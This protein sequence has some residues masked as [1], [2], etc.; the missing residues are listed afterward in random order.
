VEAAPLIAFL[1][2]HALGGTPFTF[3]AAHLEDQGGRTYPFFLVGYG[4]P[5][6][7]SKRQYEAAGGRGP[8][9][10]LTAI[11]RDVRALLSAPPGWSLL[12]LDF[13]AC[14]AAI[15]MALSGDEQLARDLEDDV[16]QTIGDMVAPPNFSPPHRRALGKQLNNSMLFGMTSH[17]VRELARDTLGRDALDGTGEGVSGAWWA[18]YPRLAAFRDRV[19]ALV[20]QAQAEARGVEIVAPSGRRSRFSPA[21]VAGRVDKGQGAKSAEGAW[22][23]LFSA[24]FRAAEADLLERTFLHF[25]E[26]ATG[27]QIMLPIYDGAVLSAPVGSEDLVRTALLAAARTAAGEIGIQVRAEIKER[28]SR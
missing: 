20:A 18:R 24:A 5:I 8:R 3:N 13:K 19:R 23:S 26:Q 14:H 27:G 22:T 4:G 21:E 12:E 2:E 6:T 25:F 1:R 16:H 28:K 17:G 9:L 15:G 10:L 11:R 7:I